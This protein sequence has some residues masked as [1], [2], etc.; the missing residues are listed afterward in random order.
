MF[1]KYIWRSA[2]LTLVLA[3]MAG[4][5]SADHPSVVFGEGTAGPIVTVGG[6]TLPAG[7]FAL[8]FRWEFVNS[9]GFTDEELLHIAEDDDSVHSTDSLS[10]PSPSFGYGVTN[11]LTVGLRQ[12]Y[13]SRRN[14]REVPH[15]DEE[16]GEHQDEE[17]E[18]EEHEEEHLEVVNAGSPRGLG[19]LV[20]AMS[21]RLTGPDDGTAGVSLVAGVEI[22]TG[23]TEQ[24]TSDGHRFETDH[25]PGSGSWDPLVG[26]ALSQGFGRS[27]LHGNVIYQLNNE[28]AQ[29]TTFGDLTLFN[30]AFVHRIGGAEDHAHAPGTGAHTH[31]ET[32]WDGMIELNG[33]HRGRDETAGH[34]NENSGGDLIYLAPGLR[35]GFARKWSAFAQFAIP[36]VDEPN[37]IQHETDYR[38]LVGM[39]VGF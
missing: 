24:L 35:V 7:I 15:H 19:D 38:V 3:M 11:R 27:S 31:T 34:V 37:G 12:P 32:T 29:E 8:S 21:F 5:A 25:Q 28:G 13:V 14:I 2:L 23:S 1:C 4:P 9:P 16:E 39:G 20:A 30:L 36:I 33:E 26:V 6:T 22:P 18:E 10:V 17:A